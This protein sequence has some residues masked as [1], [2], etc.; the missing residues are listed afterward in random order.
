[1]ATTPRLL[2]AFALVTLAFP[3]T[4]CNVWRARQQARAAQ[5]AEQQARD[6]ARRAA[7]QARQAEKEQKQ[8]A[9][10]SG[11]PEADNGPD[12]RAAASRFTHVV[13]AETPYYKTGLQQG[14]PPDGKLKA[15]TRVAVVREDG[16]YTLIR[17]E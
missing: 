2:L 13:L 4:G 15:G 8:A 5:V 17:S 12:L 7:E 16:S 9:Q 10:E 14:R 1:M 6:E 11:G 3:A